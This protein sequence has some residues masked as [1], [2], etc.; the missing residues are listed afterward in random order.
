MSTHLNS[1]D[2]ALKNYY[3]WHAPIYDATRWAFLFGRARLIETVFKIAKPQ[4]KRILELGCGTG[5]NLLHLAQRFPNAEII[6][7]DLSEAMLVRAQ[8][9]VRRKLSASEQARVRLSNADVTATP[10]QFD[11][12]VCS[13][14]LSMTG[15]QMALLLARLHRCLTPTGRLAIVDFDQT[16]WAWFARWMRRNHVRM[17]GSLAH[18]L[19]QLGRAE[20]SQTHSGFGLWR[21]LLWVGR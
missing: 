12:I 13:Y 7:C 1:N 15:D 21:W 4:P 2:R 8:A 14:V 17:D 20:I 6:G 10:L 18:T 9:N 19:V 3:R 16:R 11:L 5:K